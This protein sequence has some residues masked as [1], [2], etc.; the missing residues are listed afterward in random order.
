LQ[1]SIARGLALFPNCVQRRA[2][3]AL[4][5]RHGEA[6]ELLQCFFYTFNL[7]MRKPGSC[8]GGVAEVPTMD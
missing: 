4:F 3:L 7:W 8:L 1:F 5:D 2:R 6:V